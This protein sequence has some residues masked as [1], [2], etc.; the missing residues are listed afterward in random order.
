LKQKPGMRPG[1]ADFDEDT[2]VQNVQRPSLFGRRIQDR[3]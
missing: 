3:K 1:E 2:G